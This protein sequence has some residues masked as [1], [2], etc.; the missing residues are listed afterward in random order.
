MTV[1]ST[2]IVSAIPAQTPATT[3]S[4]SLRW[5]CAKGI[6]L[7]LGA[8]DFELADAEPRVDHEVRGIPPDVRVHVVAV[9][10]VAEDRHIAPA[11]VPDHANGRVRRNDY[12]DMPDPG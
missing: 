7:M 10:V 11:D 1:G 5:T 8:V 6:V 12:V 2:S 4:W 3:R 9:L